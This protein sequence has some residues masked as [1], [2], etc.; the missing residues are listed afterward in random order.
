MQAQR[1]LLYVPVTAGFA[2]IG[3]RSKCSN[4]PAYSCSKRVFTY[5]QKEFKTRLYS[6]NAAW[7]EENLLG[8][9]TLEKSTGTHVTEG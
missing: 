4:T 8:N 5:F 1:A 6:G 3:D 2:E 7:G 9:R